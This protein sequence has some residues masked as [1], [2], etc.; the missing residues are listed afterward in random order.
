MPVNALG[1]ILTQRISVYD[2]IINTLSTQS[3]FPAT[4]ALTGEVIELIDALS[5][6]L[7]R[8]ELALV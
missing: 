8:D 4:S 7:A 5:V 6:V 3:P 1:S 2:A